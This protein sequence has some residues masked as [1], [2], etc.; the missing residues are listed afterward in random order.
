MGRYGGCFD[1]GCGVAPCGPAPCGFGGC[2]PCGGFGNYYN[3]GYNAQCANANNGALAEDACCYNDNN[4]YAKCDEVYYAKSNVVCNNNRSAA[5]N[6]RRAC[7]NNYNNACKA[8]YNN[9][10]FNSGGCGPYAA[11]FYGGAGFRKG[12]GVGYAKGRKY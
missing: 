3:D 12:L 11:P 1:G 8:G 5:A 10:A 2:G 4:T 9:G 7:C 6:N